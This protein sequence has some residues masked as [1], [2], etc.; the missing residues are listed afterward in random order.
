MGQREVSRGPA[1]AQPRLGRPLSS[2]GTGLGGAVML[3][4]VSVG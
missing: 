4:V 3:R 2:Q 1:G